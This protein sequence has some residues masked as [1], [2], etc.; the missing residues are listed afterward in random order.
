MNDLNDKISG[1][2]VTVVSGIIFVGVV[3]LSPLLSAAASSQKVGAALVTAITSFGLYRLF[4]IGIRFAF[5]R[6]QSV[7]K[8][9]LGRYFLEGTWVGH[10]IHEERHVFTVEVISQEKGEPKVVGRQ[11]GEDGKTQA[12]WASEVAIIDRQ[13]E[14]LI[15]VYSCDVYRT[16]HQQN[17]IGIFK[18]VR[19][20]SKS[21][22]DVLDGYAVDLVDADKDC[23]TEYKISDDEVATD[24]ALQ[25]AKE[26]FG[27]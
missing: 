9:L 18:L 21:A 16:K 12:D 27:V 13:K 20:S 7:R 3:F 26:K 4:T 23:N 19:P 22:P 17:G 10:W 25:K 8:F 6:F 11:F 14:H 2:S 5:G 15:Y 24:Y 1:L